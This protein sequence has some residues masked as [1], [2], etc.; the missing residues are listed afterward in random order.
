MQ[1][2]SA[3]KSD[4]KLFKNSPVDDDGQVNDRGQVNDDNEASDEDDD[5]DS[6]SVTSSL[7]ACEHCGEEYCTDPE[8]GI[9]QVAR[10]CKPTLVDITYPPA[11]TPV[12]PLRKKRKLDSLVSRA[13]EQA[14]KFLRLPKFTMRDTYYTAVPEARLK[15]SSARD[16]MT[17]NSGK[18]MMNATEPKA[19]PEKQ[20][21]KLKLKI[22][23]EDSIPR[24][25]YLPRHAHSGQADQEDSFGMEP[26]TPE[27]RK[28]DELTDGVRIIYKRKSPA[29][30]SPRFSF[31]KR[32]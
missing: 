27:R 28:L 22:P 11:S 1:N 10:V 23:A 5:S 18:S 16:S 7:E 21:N 20:R 30:S 12:K 4:Q 3:E 32:D 8:I 24:D 13:K 15:H 29:K 26:T 19:E 25:Y 2:L 17:T 14:S 31:F 9:A 6:F